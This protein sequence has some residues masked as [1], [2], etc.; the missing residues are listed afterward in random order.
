MCTWQFNFK[1]DT[2]T[3]TFNPRS[4]DLLTRSGINFDR[5]AKEG[6]SHK[7]FAEYFMISGLIANE[8]MTWAGFHTDH[9]FAYLLRIIS[10]ENIPG[11]PQYF[12][13][14]LKYYFPT[15]VDLKV[16]VEQTLDNDLRGG[17]SRLASVLGV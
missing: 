5:L 9:D 16:I 7:T 3:E 15:V 12:L 2:K 10:G 1:F 4:I 6:V 8:D 14:T 11:N 13:T 17:L